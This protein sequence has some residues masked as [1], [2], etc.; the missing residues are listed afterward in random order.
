MR[1]C[2]RASIGS[3]LAKCN[4]GVRSRCDENLNRSYSLICTKTAAST[5]LHNRMVRVMSR[6]LR[7]CK[8]PFAIED[9]S[10]FI[11]TTGR[12]Q[13]QFRIDIVVPPDRLRAGDKLDELPSKSLMMDIT[14][15]N[16]T[17]SRCLGKY[18]KEPRSALLAERATAKENK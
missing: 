16:P 11:R 18:G 2:Q 8:I 14:I 1:L 6:T 7:Q 15:V 9:S 12:G 4:A 10:R 13:G 3:H 17:A 5:F